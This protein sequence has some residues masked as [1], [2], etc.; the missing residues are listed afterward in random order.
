MTAAPRPHSAGVRIARACVIPWRALCSVVGVAPE[1][2]EVERAWLER[3]NRDDIVLIDGGTGS[4]LQRRGVDMSPA[5]WSALASREHRAA[6]RGIHADFIAA[7]ADIVTTNTFA[8]SRFV[9]DAAGCGAAFEDLNRS[10]VEAALEA[11]E[12]AADRPVAIAGSISCLPPNFDAGAYP[13]AAKE[14]RAYD[15]LAQLL[16]D[17]GVDLI[18]LEMIQDLE[19]G[20]LAIEASL[21]TGLPVCLGVSARSVDAGLACFDF[22]DRDFGAV[23]DGLIPFGPAVVNVMHTP[24]EDV[25]AAL[26]AVGRRWHGLLGAY[27]ELPD[28]AA[29]GEQSADRLSPEKLVELAVSWVGRGARLLGGCCGAAPEHIAALAR[30]RP[31]LLEARARR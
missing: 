23:V 29:H 8:T 10:A 31:R 30:A 19:H 25:G 18:A 15:E 5:A 28:F 27:P 1:T 6:L 11:R 17:L 4:E 13:S 26:E 2:A 7:G 12:L 14:R 3:L 24:P 22:P 9:L 21:T 20:Q 16:A